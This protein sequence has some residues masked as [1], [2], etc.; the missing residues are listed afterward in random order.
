MEVKEEKTTRK[1][2]IRISRKQDFPRYQKILIK[3]GTIIFSILLCAFISNCISSGSFGVFLQNVFVNNFAS[4]RK[5]V[6]S[7]SLQKT[8]SLLWST[9]ILFLIA[10]AVTPAFKM[11]FWNI[12]GEG[13]ILMGGFGALIV[14]KFLAPGIRNN[15]AVL[16][17][18]LLFA[19]TFGAIWALIPTIF[20]CIFNTN[21][22]LFTL[23][24]NYISMAI[25]GFFSYEWRATGKTAI[26]IVNED[27][28][29]GRIPKVTM[30]DGKS[31]D[32][33][34]G[35]IIVII[36]AL[37]LTLYLKYFKHGYEISVIGG[38]RNTAKYVGISINKVTIRTMLLSGA[39]AG[40]CGWLLVAAGS[41][42][43]N[44]TLVNG[45][46]FTGVLISW[47]GH[48]NTLEM[49]AYSFLVS[50]ISIGSENAASVLNYSSSVSSILVG[51][52]FLLIIAS[53]FFVNFKLT[54]NFNF[55]RKE[56]KDGSN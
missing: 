9:A 48:F 54:F 23:M 13:Q 42:S 11:K 10:L 16:T 33:I 17:L 52:F 49:A 51:V 2:L 25:V 18:M 7:F 6:T 5:G 27:T 39:L 50:F 46:G 20:K 15:F 1:P 29:L 14:M 53:E 19:M 34:I 40:L 22:T 43:I 4:V 30:F 38:S 47:L 37:I 12:G 32:Y 35:I 24:M 45:R 36:I 28:K 8:I 56:R 21:E 41:H 3:L 31:Y 44:E 26:G 55:L